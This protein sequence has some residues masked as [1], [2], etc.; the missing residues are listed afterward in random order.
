[1][2]KK[3]LFV[4]PSLEIGGAEKSLIN[5]L[6]LMD[7]DKYE[8]DLF[9]LTK[10][11]YADVVPKQVNMVSH[12]EDFVNFSKGLLSACI[13]FL[14]QRK[15]SLLLSRIIFSIINRILPTNKAEQ[16]SW[17][18]LRK[19]I[20]VLPQQYDVAIGYLEK[21]SIYLAVDC[22]IASKK[23][24]FIRV[25][26]EALNLN[27]NFDLKYFNQ[28]TYLCANGQK[29]YH[30]LKKNF[31]TSKFDIKLIYNST[32]K[33]KIQRLQKEKLEVATTNSLV[34]VGRL[35]PQK[36]YDLT[37]ETAKQLVIRNVD[38]KWYIVGD[39]PQKEELLKLIRDAGL[40]NQVFL[41]G[42]KKNPYPYMANC[43]I[44]VQTSYYEGRSNTILEAMLL[45]RPI[46]ATNF[47]SVAD[48]ITCPAEGMIVDMSAN[49]IA[50]AIQYLFDNPSIRQSMSDHLLQKKNLSSDSLK[51]FYDLLEENI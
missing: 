1:M 32:N 11:E 24:G 5:L 19:S 20:G 12:S 51:T 39:G 4:I 49:E 7:Y 23:I 38:F 27:R 10:K 50:D 14:K 18:F 30:I 25:N 42:E 29:S 17:L 36:G 41:T 16:Y 44:Y 37:I 13:Q 3:L 45:G 34:S 21:S 48:L 35:H 33:N 40:T 15:F 31:P 46:V 43:N 22:A 9:L 26:Y 8:V 47:E 6:E 2:K 28:L